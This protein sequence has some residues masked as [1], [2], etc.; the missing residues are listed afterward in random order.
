[1]HGSS[2]R[3]GTECR[4]GDH[5]NRLPVGVRTLD[6][7]EPGSVP[8][9]F[10]RIGIEPLGVTLGAV[11]T[12]ADLRAPL[13]DEL[14]AE[15]DLAFRE[16]KVIVFRDQDLT[17]EQQG[18]FA[19]RWGDVVEDSLPR[20]VANGGR[21]VAL[22]R[23]VDNVLPFTRDGIVAGLENV[24]HADGSYREAPVLGTMLRAVDVPPLGGDTMFADMA[25]AYDN[26]DPRVQERVESLW[27]CHDWSAGGYTE[28]YAA[29]W[30]EYRSAVPPVRQPVVLRHPRTG[31]KTLFVN[32]GFVRHIIGLPA[33]ESEELLEILCRQADVP[34]YQLRI[35]WEPNLLVLW[36]NFA[37]QHYAVNDYWPQT[38]TLVRATI[39]A[40]VVTGVLEPAALTTR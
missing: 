2:K 23:M 10:R 32:R 12:G 37:V 40:G 26:L 8:A 28:K 13:D 24:W 35:R 17:L 3:G 5:M 39:D 27:A 16:W 1:M 4:R 11:V 18:A 25:A 19:S 30:D 29:T 21:I 33:E 31:R 22:P 6:R 38:R 20:Q 7:A 14:F 9:R 34:E 36:D 15:I